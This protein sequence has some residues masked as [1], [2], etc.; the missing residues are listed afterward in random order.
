[1]AV[2]VPPVPAALAAPAAP[3]APAAALPPLPPKGPDAPAPLDITAQSDIDFASAIGLGDLGSIGNEQADAAQVAANWSGGDATQ[4]A[5][6][7]APGDTRVPDTNEQQAAAEAIATGDP[8]N[9]DPANPD[10][11][12]PAA[13]PANPD[14]AAPAR[15]P[16]LQSLGDV[17]IVDA[18]G[19]V[20]VDLLET[21]NITMKA[22]GK[23]ET[24]NLATWLRR[25]QNGAYN[26]GLQQ[27][28]AAARTEIPRLNTEL[29]TRDRRLD[30]QQQLIVELLTDDSKLEE[31]RAE[32]ARATSPESQMDALRRR[33]TDLEAQLR[34]EHA[35]G[36]QGA[37]ESQR[38]KWARETLTPSV[39]KTL[40]ANPSLKAVDVLGRFDLLTRHL[41]DGQGRIPPQYFE[42]AIGIWDRDVAPWAAQ[43]HDRNQSIAAE[44]AAG[45]RAE[46]QAQ[47]RRAQAQAQVAKN[48]LARTTTIRPTG[49][50]APERPGSPSGG[51]ASGT[52]GTPREALDSILADV[53]AAVSSGKL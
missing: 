34:G 6:A 37:V 38:A 36:T 29:Q 15:S 40:G 3:A 10:P 28:A 8:A 41:R 26:E 32:W 49:S 27:E 1:M 4:Q 7:P 5:A 47:V 22:G 35:P 17:K 23:V 18:E 52:P 44:A 9:P 24:H 51:T 46:G 16:L 2:S 31:H 33:N 20:P 12:A 48:A 39:A 30:D 13:D 19:D 25:G 42:A 53:G 14:P 11:A 50:A 43:V 45:A 21:I